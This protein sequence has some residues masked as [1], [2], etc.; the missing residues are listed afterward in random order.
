MLECW[1]G[2][3]PALATLGPQEEARLCSLG[4]VLR[5]FG[6]SFQIEFTPE[7]I[8]GEQSSGGCRIGFWKWAEILPVVWGQAVGTIC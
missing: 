1:N 5:D 2:L 3:G 6:V 7:Q 4:Q 8:E